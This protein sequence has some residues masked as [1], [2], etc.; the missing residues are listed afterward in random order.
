MDS[1]HR[2]KLKPLSGMILIS[3]LLFFQALT[4]LGLM[5]LKITFLEM[6]AVREQKLREEEINSAKNALV[7][8]E[9]N[10][11]TLSLKCKIERIPTQELLHYDWWQSHGCKENLEF[12]SY[13][14]LIENLGENV[15]GMIQEF[16]LLA[17]HY[18][19]ITLFL[20]T[21][22][23]ILLQSTFILTFDHK[24]LNCYEKMVVVKPGRQMLREFPSNSS[25]F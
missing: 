1:L 2:I 12:K 15:C 19:R 6:K 17:T 8:I 5:M 7:E 4:L 22:S 3:T 24:S 13:Y 20:N 18:F 21:K 25:S 16:P 10:L 11:F 9:K 23:P 14:Y